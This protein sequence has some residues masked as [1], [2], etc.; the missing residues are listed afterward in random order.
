MTALE[1]AGH[2]LTLR[3]RFSV[4]ISSWGRTEKHNRAVKGE[5]NSRHL[6]FEAVDCVLDNEKDKAAFTEMAER[7]GLKVVPESDHI[8][9]QTK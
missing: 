5:A 4:S 8:H 7:L 3:A 6:S 1:F 9:I 2:V